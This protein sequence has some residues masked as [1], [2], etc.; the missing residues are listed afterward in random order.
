MEKPFEGKP[1]QEP[2]PRLELKERAGW[3]HYGSIPYKIYYDLVSGSSELVDEKHP[4][5][6]RVTPD[7]PRAGEPPAYS[8]S[9]W[10]HESVPEAFKD[11][12]IF[13]ELTEAELRIVG[14][15]DEEEGHQRAVAA[16]ERYARGHLS[17][18]EFAAFETWQKG[19]DGY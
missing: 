2:S 15:L 5:F 4:G 11:I 12:V 6:Y 10:V 7:R 8:L 13:H 9:V 3:Y 18:E 14:G 19:L 16:T 1:P 17:S